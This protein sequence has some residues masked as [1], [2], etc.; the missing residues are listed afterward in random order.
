MV[1]LRVEKKV[2]TTVLMMVDEW[3]G[4]TVARKAEHLAAELVGSRVEET[5]AEMAAGMVEYMD[6]K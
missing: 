4:L 6:E 5:V 3:G 1:A 2:V